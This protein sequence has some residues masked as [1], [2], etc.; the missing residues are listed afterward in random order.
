MHGDMQVS[1]ISDGPLDFGD[2][3]KLM[4]EQTMEEMAKHLEGN[5]LAADH[6]VLQ[7]NITV[8]N[9]GS[10]IAVFDTG[11]GASKMFGENQGK[12]PANLKAAGIDPANVDAVILSH[13]HPD[14][15]GGL[16]DKDGKSVFPNAQVLSTK[17]TSSS[18]RMRNFSK[19]RIWPA[20]SSSRATTCSPTRIR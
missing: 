15:A 5:F 19:T 18:G 4:K 16:V 6:M 8:V 9:T 20:L 3:R 7:Q 14:H 13:C 12:M 11:M 1:V 10:K 17:P 2:G